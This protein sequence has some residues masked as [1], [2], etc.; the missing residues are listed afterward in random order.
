M[1]AVMKKLRQIYK[2][3]SN[4][5]LL[6]F[7][8]LFM[9]ASTVV[10]YFAFVQKRDNIKNAHYLVESETKK[11]QYAIDSRLLDIEILEMLVISH[12]GNVPD[13]DGVASQLFSGD[14]ALLSLQIAPDGIITFVYPAADE[15]EVYFDL[16]RDPDQSAEAI[17]A[18]DTGEMTLAGPQELKQGGMGVIARNP[19]FLQKEDGSK[20]FWGFSTAVLGI[21][22]LFD[23]ADLSLLDNQKYY[24]RIWRIHPDSGKPQVISENT[25]HLFMHPVRGTITV[26]NGTWY[27]D[28]MPQNGWMPAHKFL[29]LC[30]VALVIVLL[31]TFVL[32]GILTILQQRQDLVR[33]TNMDPLTGIKNNRYFLNMLKDLADGDVPFTIFYLDMNDFKQIN[34]RYGHDM[35]DLVLKE[36]AKRICQCISEAD[37]ATRIGGDEF[38]VTT[39]HTLTVEDC[40]KL[41]SALRE[42]VGEVMIL[43]KKTTYYPSISIGYARFPHES[44]D[45][46]SVIRLADQRMYEEKRSMKRKA[47][48]TRNPASPHES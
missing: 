3:N 30:S 42:K 14:P 40:L 11:I 1:E 48:E 47:D 33:Q 19:I 38:T 21:P 20:S 31:S 36:T 35:G 46:E 29:L 28:I 15:E 13:F 17:R 23:M 16:F 5:L 41:K 7:L 2:E 27:L 4:T 25:E 39:T 43:N 18:R 34:D 8:L 26:P 12:D 9:A 32:A 6:S 10:T 44:S 22:E 37:T 45:V 24:Y